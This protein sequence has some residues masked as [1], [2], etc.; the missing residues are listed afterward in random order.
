MHSLCLL[1]KGIVSRESIFS[2]FIKFCE[3][4]S[5]HFYVRWYF[6]HE[7]FCF[8]FFPWILFSKPLKIRLGSF[9]T[10]SKNSAQWYLQVK[11]H[12]WYQQH[13]WEICRRCQLHR[14]QICTGINNSGGKFAEKGGPQISSANRKF[15]GLQ[16][17]LHLRTFRK[18]GICGFADPTF[19]A[20]W[21]PNCGF[22]IANW[23]QEF[24]DLQFVDLKKNIC[25]HLCK[26]ATIVNDTGGKFA[27]GVK[28][29]DGIND[30]N[31]NLPLVSMTPVVNFPPVSVT[32]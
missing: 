30:T 24:A 22:L 19:F 16:N 27:D 28:F 11:V 10:F 25:A 7:I 14:W 32:R 2:I 9:Q 8:R 23:A 3:V 6:A 12:H 26:F 18:C 1:L 13:S 17:L 20:I 29:A 4:I 31:G 15:A 5:V 21:T